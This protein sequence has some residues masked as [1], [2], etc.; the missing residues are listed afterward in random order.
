MFLGPLACL[1]CNY[2]SDDLESDDGEAMNAFE[3]HSRG[4]IELNEGIEL[5]GAKIE[6]DDGPVTRRSPLPPS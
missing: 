1:A 5:L 2:D 6:Y 3:E 4:S